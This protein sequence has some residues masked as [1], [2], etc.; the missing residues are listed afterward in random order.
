M[1]ISQSDDS[2]LFS[3]QITDL[4]WDSEYFKVKSG[5]VLLNQAVPQSEQKLILEQLKSYQFVTIVN[6][7][8]DPVNNAWIGQAST[9]FLTDMNMQ[10]VKELDA[11]VEEQ[12]QRITC[13]I[14]DKYPFNGDLLH[15]ARSSFQ[16][17]R[18]FN[19]P[20]LPATQGRLIYEHW[21]RQ[22]F[23][24]E[25][26]Y[27]VTAAVE[28]RA[29]G[30]LLFDIN[31]KSKQATI[32]LIAVHQSFRGQRIGRTLIQ[33]MERRLHEVGMKQIKVGTQADNNGA[34]SFYQACGYRYSHCNAVYHY[35][36]NPRR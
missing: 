28:G 2:K 27:F 22:A 5:K 24:R 19:D 12:E 20:L 13:C 23:D 11:S 6:S 36:P 26:R 30:Y 4:A 15:M 34:I 7:G 31:E 18:F 33:T 8:N 29:A 35:W 3:Y 10:F 16:Y 32:E 17:S 9:A 21:T 25:G 14:Q 1:S